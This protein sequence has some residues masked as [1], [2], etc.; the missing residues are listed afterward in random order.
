MATLTI[1]RRLYLIASRQSVEPAD[2]GEV[3]V[4]AHSEASLC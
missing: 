1:T 4:F 3:S 2:K